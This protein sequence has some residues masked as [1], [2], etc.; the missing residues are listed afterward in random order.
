MYN[1]VP[2]YFLFMGKYELLKWPLFNI[3]F[4]G[5]N[6]AVNRGS[7]TGGGQGVQEG[8]GGHPQRIP[9]RFPSRAP[10]RDRAAA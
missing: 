1:V 5:M 4:K 6:I 8:L 2:E 7:H 10:F 9:S 3:F